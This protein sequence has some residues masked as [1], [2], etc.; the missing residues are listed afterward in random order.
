MDIKKQ[1]RSGSQKMNIKI[2]RK[3]KRKER[4]AIA[5]YYKFKNIR[6]LK[7]MKE[8]RDLLCTGGRG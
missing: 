2:C 5:E 8:H 3:E 1:P 6:F 7:N 4:N